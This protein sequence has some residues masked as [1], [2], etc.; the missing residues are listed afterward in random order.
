MTSILVMVLSLLLT[1]IMVTL[2]SRWHQQEVIEM[3]DQYIVFQYE[4]MNLMESGSTLLTG[5]EAYLR[6]KGSLTNDES[7]AFLN[8]LTEEEMIYIRNIGVLKDTTIVY[9]FPLEGN[10][11]SIGVDLA[12]VESQRT[13][14]LQTKES[15]ES[16]IAG[17][18]ELVQGGIGYIIRK[19]LEDSNNNYWGQISIVLRA[20][21]IDEA[22]DGFKEAHGL[23]LVIYE[24]ENNE[25]LIYGDPAILNQK[26]LTFDFK[27]EPSRWVVY[28]VPENGWKKNSGPI[29]LVL[30]IGLALISGVVGIVYYVQIIHYNLQKALAHDQL[31]GL[32]SRYY[33]E[34]V[35]QE[36]LHKAKLKQVSF[37]LMHIDLNSFKSINDMYG[38]EAGDSVLVETARVLRLVTR[39]NELVFRIG[40][41]EFLVMMPLVADMEELNAFKKRLKKGFLKHYQ[42]KEYDID[43][44]PS[45][46]VG[47]YP[48]D[49]ESFDLVLRHADERMY[50]EKGDSR[51]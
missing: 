20:E 14:V 8:H 47:L 30:I 42:L 39:K 33:L 51:R 45:I 22:I 48:E 31:T 26:P 4:V 29:A 44:G 16:F 38:H 9:N 50:E 28:L 6:V 17:P 37:G 36:I 40:G 19:P 3:T 18:V 49:G 27:S 34:K 24:D 13:L 5:Y 32:Y 21:K 2:N 43:I 15:G 10:E 41:D 46:G 35:Q 7:E 23:D 1:F 25:K 12:Q 11:S